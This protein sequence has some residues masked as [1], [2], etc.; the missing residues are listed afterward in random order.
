MH[1][2]PDHDRWRPLI[3]TGLGACSLMSSS[4]VVRAQETAPNQ[5]EIVVTA[6]SQ[7]GA[8]VGL[9]QAETSIDAHVVAAMGASTLADVIAQL[10]AQT[11]GNQGRTGE[12]SV[13]LLNGRRISSIAEVRNLPP[14]AVSRVDILPEEAALRFG[15]SAHQKVINIVLLP[16]FASATGELEDRLAEATA[17]NDF[18]VEA[19]LVRIAGA[20]RLTA[21][22]QYQ[23][24]DDLTEARR[25]IRSDPPRNGM[26]RT[27]VPL[28]HQFSADSTFARAL[29]NGLSLSATA[30]FDHLG[31]RA[32]IGPLM[33]DPN[34]ALSRTTTTDTAHAGGILSG[35]L[36]GWQ[37]SVTG[38]ADR[39][40]STIDTAADGPAAAR[41]SHAR[42]DLFSVET[43]ASGSVFSL[44]AGAANLSLQGNASTEN[45]AARDED[46][47]DRRVSRRILGGQIALEVPLLSGHSPIGSLS[48]G[49][50]VFLRDYSDASVPADRGWNLAW[51][52]LG[53]LNIVVA[54]TREAVLPTMRQLG[55]PLS[56]T[57]Q[58]RFFDYGT[59][60][61]IVAT[62][63]DGG[64]PLLRH[65]RRDLFK[66]EG[67]VKPAK[68]LAVIA[69]YTD[70]RL[71]D[72][73]I[74]FPGI[75]PALE[76]AL[77][78]RV[79]R[80]AG[81]AILSVDARPF[82]AA[83]ED[84]K[85]LRLGLNFSKSWAGGGG[86]RLPGGG[87]FG[88]GHSFGQSGT[89][90]QVALYDNWRLSDRLTLSEGSQPIDLLRGEVLGDGLR[91]PRHSLEAQI[92][93][94]H[95]GFGLR[96]NTVWRTSQT[97]APG[98]SGQ[99]HF[100]E[101]VTTNLRLFFFPAEQEKLARTMPWLKGVRFLLAIDNLFDQSV[102]V[103]NGS[104]VVPAAYQR[105]LLDPLGRSFRLSIR[106]TF[107]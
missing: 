13:I 15:Y 69:T 20:N 101:P 1:G 88:G 33:S 73:L 53:P 93:G 45:L 35:H 12:G 64:D 77:P 25:G 18:N 102:T 44:P 106:K 59:A 63:I 32:L 5:A 87:R 90:V 24:G 22:L 71:T 16:H 86:P 100:A 92:S 21:N 47:L 52:P 40:A 78:G 98:L 7:P 3:L 68:G 31:S 17:R 84:R 89:T 54:G 85:D 14:E 28:T 80:D 46:G 82:N 49:A 56:Q 8:V 60:Q 30:N 72:P 79:F 9:F 19:N 107:D 76:A 38:N 48:G 97:V 96:A 66:I 67:T 27:V 55:D 34:R 11:G 94:T 37:W 75:S 39:I 10:S 104:G 83:R 105:G 58:V 2:L 29:G 6:R 95:H 103:R 70:Q 23:I 50:S 26:L 81:G 41:T 4:V 51:Q 36:A 43:V 42:D 99:L 74:L 57:P 62:R 61:S 91:T 65:D